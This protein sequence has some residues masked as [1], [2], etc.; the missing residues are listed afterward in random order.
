MSI[1]HVNIA[2]LLLLLEEPFTHN[3]PSSC[4]D[5]IDQAVS[6][7]SETCLLS[8]STP[9]D[10]CT[11][12]AAP[13]LPEV[14]FFAGLVIENRVQFYNKAPENKKIKKMYIYVSWI[15]HSY[16]WHTNTALEVKFNSTQAGIT[17]EL[18]HGRG[19]SCSQ[20]SWRLTL[21]RRPLFH[22]LWTRWM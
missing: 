14:L 11:L 9:A 20:R 10:K 12:T 6:E 3:S 18:R 5:L 4:F 19:Y 7:T 1:K 8:W 16:R 21:T 2:A 22:H 13:L 15:M 17:A